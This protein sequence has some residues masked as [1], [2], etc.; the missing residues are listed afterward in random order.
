MDTLEQLIRDNRE[1]IQNDLPPEGHIERFQLKLENNNRKKSN[2]WIGFI[3][4]IAAVLLLGIFIFLSQNKN[5]GQQMTLAKVSDQYK[6]VEFYYTSTISLQTEKLKEISKKMD[7]DPN[8]KM[9]FKE[10]NDYDQVYAQICKDLDATP[11][12]ERVINAMITYYQTKLEIINR[13]LKE[14]ESKQV[15]NSDHENTK[16]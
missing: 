6:E 5:D 11:N 3:S 16:I 1:H 12:D 13:I 15:K 9:I 7:D 14:I 4:G 10:L 2:Y 8:M